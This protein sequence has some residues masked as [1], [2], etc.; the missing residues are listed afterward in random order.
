M[1]ETEFQGWRPIVGDTF[2]WEPI[3]EGCLLFEEG[4]GKLLTLNPSAEAVLTHCDGEQTVG[5]IVGTLESDWGIPPTETLNLL[6]RLRDEG[7]LRAD[8]KE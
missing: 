3:P 2:S 8:P 5:E 4:T 6:Q 1:N 7:V